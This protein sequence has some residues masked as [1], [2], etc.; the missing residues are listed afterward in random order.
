VWFEF[1]FSVRGGVQVIVLGLDFQF[2]NESF[3]LSV[4]I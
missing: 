4:W 3:R 2:E 1:R